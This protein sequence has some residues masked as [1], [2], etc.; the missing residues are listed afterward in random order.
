MAQYT[1]EQ[2]I[3][4]Y[5][6]LLKE[7]AELKSRYRPPEDLL[8]LP[9]AEMLALLESST[10][11]KKEQMISLLSMFEAS[12]AT[13][14]LFFSHLIVGPALLALAYTVAIAVQ[15]ANWRWVPVALLAAGGGL[16]AMLV[17]FW[18]DIYAKIPKWKRWGLLLLFQLGEAI[19]VIC[20][21]AVWVRLVIISSLYGLYQSVWVRLDRFGIFAALL[22]LVLGY[23][24]SKQLNAF[25]F[26]ITEYTR[27]RK[28]RG[29]TR[30]QA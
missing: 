30:V 10:H 18:V 27:L 19:A 1:S 21:S 15:G 26:F 9:K 20:W 6:K 24:F 2:V 16:L 14:D 4:A 22:S 23:F 29:G 12:G 28:F 17:P 5:E 25:F 3:T 8:P 11:P 13:R 7:I